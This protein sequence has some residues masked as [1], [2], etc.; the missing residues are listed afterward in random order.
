MREKER[1]KLKF[2]SF[3]KQMLSSPKI[4]F[5]IPG[6]LLG[7]GEGSGVE[8]ELRI[9]FTHSSHSMNHSTL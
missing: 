2:H 8:E 9:E 7:G 5:Q 1:E 4:P 6:T 3:F